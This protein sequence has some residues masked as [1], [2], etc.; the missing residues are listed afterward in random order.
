MTT[1]L[2]LRLDQ[3]LDRLLEEQKTKTG[4]SKNQ[5][6]VKACEKMVSEYRRK[7]QENDHDKNVKEE[8]K[9][10]PE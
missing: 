5:L 10:K 7:V 8:S 2:T 6:I 3:K 4:L 1:R 9:R